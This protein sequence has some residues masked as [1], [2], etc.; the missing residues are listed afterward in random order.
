M[1]IH[2]TGA[3]LPGI[4]FGGIALCTYTY[5]QEPGRANFRGLD[6]V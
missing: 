1:G 2:S 6:P 3:C 4:G 5:N